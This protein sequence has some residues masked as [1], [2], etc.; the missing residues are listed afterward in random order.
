[1]R[2]NPLK[3]DPDYEY[4]AQDWRR[5]KRHNRFKKISVIFQTAILAFLAWA[6]VE[7]VF[8]TQ[9]PEERY[10]RDQWTQ[11][12]GFIALSYRG[13]SL[14]E[15]EGD[16]YVSRKQFEEH[17]RVLVNAGYN[18]ITTEDVV[19]YYYRNAP[20]PDKALYLMFEDGRKDSAVFSMN[21]LKKYNL[22]AAMYLQTAY[23]KQGDSFFIRS[24]EL[25]ALARNPYW[26]IG[27]QGYELRYIN[28]MPDE[29]HSFF[30]TDYLRNEDLDP[31]ETGEE[32]LR[33]F[34]TDYELSS[35]L[36]E[37]YSGQK[38]EAYIFMPANTLWRSLDETVEAAN[39]RLLDR[40]YKVAFAREGSCFN[41]RETAPFN[42]T[43]LQVFP[44]WSVNRLLMEIESSSPLRHAYEQADEEQNRLWHTEAGALQFS[45]QA[46]VLTAP[47]DRE[48]H[49]WLRGT[50]AWDN[51]DLSVKC[52][53]SRQGAQ[54]IYLR[55]TSP[56]S[57]ICVEVSRN[58]VTVRERAEGGRL[59]TLYEA[60]LGYNAAAEKLR[61]TLIGNRLTLRRGDNE[62][63]VS[64]NIIPVSQS[65]RR[66]RVAVGAL[67]EDEPYD[68]VF[69]A[70]SLKPITHLWALPNPG[71]ESGDETRLSGDIRTGLIIPQ[72]E[73]MDEAWRNNGPRALYQALDEGQ[74]I[75]GALPEDVYDLETLKRPWATLPQG[76]AARFLSG[77]ILA[78]GEDP[79]WNEAGQA[80][81]RAQERNLAVAVRLSPISAASLAESESRPPAD[82]IMYDFEEPLPKDLDTKLKARY[83]QRHFLK[84]SGPGLPQIYTWSG[85]VDR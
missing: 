6:F 48:A 27:S 71:A 77:V 11:R 31:I 42:L 46:M 29:G 13:I 44:Y 3:L 67:G 85:E 32:L 47:K 52:S 15:K 81:E 51:V 59:N 12:D 76:M 18:A 50:D 26:D 60:F 68:A 34:E 65:V 20:L 17:M 73:E 2:F 4:T 36:I 78:P 55:Y 41:T 19:N 70:M 63:P 21:T 8:S 74:M 64:K 38:P 10:P 72:G 75:F 37:E 24:A 69:E 49:A 53:G 35:G 39:A 83:D 84:L 9:Q 66:G 28:V 14:R 45:G 25:K 16:R 43:R 7:A 57:Y 79:D 33:R 54:K 5:L 1:M 58:S 56:R 40:H 22:R 80:A 62:T 30:L 23:L 61:I 82:W